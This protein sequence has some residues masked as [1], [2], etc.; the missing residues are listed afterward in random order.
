[1]KR[2]LFLYLFLTVLIS[3]VTSLAVISYSSKKS[4]VY[5]YPKSD[6][7]IV[8]ASYSPQN[9]PDFTFAAENAVKAVVHVKVVKKTSPQP[10]SLF[11]FF[12]YGASI[13]RSPSL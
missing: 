11:D 3:G 12:G 7:P 5:Y 8:K 1:M 10:Y 4:S 9:F 13:L 6:T 2:N